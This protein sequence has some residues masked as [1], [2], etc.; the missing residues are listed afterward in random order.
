MC[1]CI[2]ASMRAHKRACVIRSGG[3]IISA[4]GIV[5]AVGWGEPSGRRALKDE[6]P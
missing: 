5:F 1:V 6:C 3:V 2:R 4:E